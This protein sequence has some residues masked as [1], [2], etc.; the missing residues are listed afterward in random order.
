MSDDVQFSM[1]GLMAAFERETSGESTDATPDGEAGADEGAEPEL[2]FGNLA[3]FVELQLLVSW[4]RP[5]N[6]KDTFWCPRWWC[7]AEAVQRLE[8]LW[9]SWEA[10]RQDPA[11][12]MS[13]WW[14]DH[15]DHHL[16]VLTGASGPFRYCTKDDGHATKRLARE[17][18]HS[19]TPP[20][21]LFG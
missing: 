4:S 21:G 17:R 7:H 11:T 2:V 16:S 5:I 6:D 3:D 15:A 14:R 8:A 18:L 1:D 9:R 20:E 13:V 19:E 10:L 12:G